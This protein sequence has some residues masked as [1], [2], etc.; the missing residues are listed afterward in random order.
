[1][2]RLQ[3]AGTPDVPTVCLQAD[4]VERGMRELR[5]L[6]NRVAE[7]LMAAAPNG[8]AVVVAGAGHLIPQEHPTAVRDAI[9]GVV[10]GC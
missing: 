2:R 10:A 3:A 8:R 6:L 5:P 4:R 1:M 7:E 9:L